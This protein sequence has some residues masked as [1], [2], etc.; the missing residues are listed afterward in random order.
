MGSIDTI[1][2]KAALI[3]PPSV[4]L[5]SHRLGKDIWCKTDKDF[6]NELSRVLDEIGAT[7]WLRSV[8]RVHNPF[9]VFWT[10][11]SDFKALV[12]IKHGG[13]RR[14]VVVCCTPDTGKLLLSQLS[15]EQSAAV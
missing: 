1:E 3:S 8:S 13:S 6:A 10:R 12:R 15:T 11:Y 2:I 7:F 5:Y 9:F 4:N 14:E